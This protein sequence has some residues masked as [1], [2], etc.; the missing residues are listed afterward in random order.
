[1]LCIRCGAR[2]FDDD[3]VCDRCHATLP[4][5]PDVAR[6]PARR[7]GHLETLRRLCL[8]F[9]EGT[10]GFEAL[11]QALEVI[12]EKVAA[13]AET[14]GAVIVADLDDREIQALLEEEHRMAVSGSDMMLEALAHIGAGEGHFSHG[15]SLAEKAT[16]LLNHSIETGYEVNR[17]LGVPMNR[18][19]ES[20]A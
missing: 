19:T 13:S 2:N 8:E 12:E 3:T 16:D 5:I 9:Q 20:L 17:R 4:R 14:L 1:M 18:E 11:M 15:L 10:L 7:E 6:A